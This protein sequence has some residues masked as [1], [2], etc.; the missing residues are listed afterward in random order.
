MSLGIFNPIHLCPFHIIC[1]DRPINGDTIACYNWFES[2]CELLTYTV[3][4]I[5]FCNLLKLSQCISCPIP[6]C[7]AE[8]NKLWVRVYSFAF[9]L[10]THSSD[11]VNSS[12]P[13]S[14]D[15]FGNQSGPCQAVLDSSSLGE[16]PR[17][18][19]SA[20]LSFPAQYDQCL[21]D[22]NSRISFTLL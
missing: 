19:R 2:Q 22:T 1:G 21:G 4:P 8:T 7:S 3:T 18:G 20:G 16:I 12:L 14:A 17:E 5:S 13:S 15:I 11:I 6:W 9:I 10:L